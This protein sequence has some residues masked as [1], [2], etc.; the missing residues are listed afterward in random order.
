M[1]TALLW[2][3]GRASSVAVGK[4]T[5][6]APGKR[7][8]L[9]QLRAPTVQSAT[10]ILD[11]RSSRPQFVDVWASW[12]VPCREEAPTIDKL[13]RRYGARVRFLGIDIQD[14]RVAAQDFV[15]RFG[16]GYP[17]IFDPSA[18]LAGKL[19]L[20]GIPT[21]Y[22]VDRHGRI[23]LTLIGKQSA[24]RLFQSL[25]ELAAED[26]RTLSAVRG[27]PAGR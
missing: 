24:A 8:E 23:A 9:P 27:S 10:T 14:T 17:S 13:W 3:S 12:C 21:A 19:G 1:A 16:L 15:Y 6:L 5:L 26:R 18:G 11:L 25:A 2:P 20:V 22:L 4:V 7:V